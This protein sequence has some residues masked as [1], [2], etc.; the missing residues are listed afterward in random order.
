MKRHV[1]KTPSVFNVVFFAPFAVK[2]KE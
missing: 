1:R 2:K